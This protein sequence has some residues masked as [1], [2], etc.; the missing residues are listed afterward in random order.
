MTEEIKNGVQM[1]GAVGAMSPQVAASPSSIE[2]V[3]MDDAARKIQQQKLT[4]LNRSEFI[5][6]LKNNFA[7]TVRKVFINSL[8]REV[9]FREV[10]VL[11]QKQL[12]R[13]M[14]DNE[15]RKD[16][17]YDAQ[18]ALINQVALEEGFD[19]YKLTEFDKIKLLIVLY[20]TN[21]FKNDIQFKCK[22]C[23]TE[24]QYKLDFQKVLDKLDEYDISDK[25]FTFKNANWEF[26]FTCGY[27]SVERVSEFYKSYSKKYKQA[28]T[29]KE[30]ETL[31]NMINIDYSCTFIKE[32]DFKSIV[33]ESE[34]T[35]I[36]TSEFTPQ[37][38]TQI[39][40]SFPQDVV[41]VDDGVLSFVV[42]NFINK[43]NASF[44]KH[45]CGSCGAVYDESVDG[46]TSSFL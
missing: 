7:T 25:S 37:E 14:I 21:M 31:N 22:E 39:L 24:N 23:G 9:G 26:K 40:E 36:V 19:I 12:S 18:C 29:P 32:I 45:K 44:E 43:I 15:Q 46:D 42:E 5:K 41:Y 16:I 27:P 4:V 1:L 13:I 30:L 33:G 28:R 35:R 3:V 17:V 6:A 8:G 34:P 38:V 11:E 2:G 10:T 20:Q